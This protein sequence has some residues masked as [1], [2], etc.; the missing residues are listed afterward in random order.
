[1]TYDQAWKRSIEQI[2]LALPLA[3]ELGVDIL[4]ENVW[5]NFLTDPAETARYIDE[6]NSE[7]VGAYY[8]VGNSVRYAPPLEWLGKLGKR[9]RKLD[10]KEFDLEVGKKE[11][12]GNGFRAE[13]L[14]GSCG[15][16]EVIKKLREMDYSGWATAEIPGGDEKRLAEI[17]E[18]M[19]RIFAS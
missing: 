2:R 11:G 8:A 13:L 9:I 14:E 12:W 17:F 1:M 10:I 3:E 18:R 16:P 6:I 15:W 19:D 4:L 5:N 7:R